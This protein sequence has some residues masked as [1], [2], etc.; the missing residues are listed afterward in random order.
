[1]ALEGNAG[2]SY[3]YDES[4]FDRFPPAWP[5][6]NHVVPQREGP[7]FFPHTPADFPYAMA[8]TMPMPMSSDLAREDELMGSL[9]SDMSYFDFA[10][11]EHLS[12]YNQVP[13]LS[14][15]SPMIPTTGTSF[16]FDGAGM[17]ISGISGLP[18]TMPMSAPAT[19]SLSAVLPDELFDPSTEIPR[20]SSTPHT[21]ANNE[22][23]AQDAH[24]H[25]GSPS[26]DNSE[27]QLATKTESDI[28]DMDDVVVSTAA[29]Q[30]SPS[31]PSASPPDLIH[32]SDSDDAG[33]SEVED[34]DDGDGDFVPN[35]RYKTRGR[36]VTRSSSRRTVATKEAATA[37]PES[38]RSVSSKTHTSGHPRVYKLTAPT[39]VP[40]LTKKSR[41]RRV[42]TSPV[43]VV[44]G[45]VQ[46]NA[47]G[48]TCKV[49]GCG[50]CFA[51]GEHLKRHVRSI[52]TN[53]KRTF[54]L[55]FSLHPLVS[56]SAPS[57]PRVLNFPW[58]PSFYSA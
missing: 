29:S 8:A 17:D 15:N 48:Y 40:N 37:S 35:A 9:S 52:H 13:T 56:L 31:F 22:S 12:S 20:L 25:N 6:G 47:R 54:L 32:E 19:S 38:S 2:D 44:Q 51:R 28:Q 42:P 1:M 36:P 34:G 14:R 58:R 7:T 57:I 43:L 16:Y 10:P 27:T 11:S 50:K 30:S 21:S 49:K 55:L 46:K 5:D 41:G 39:P 23:T 26:Q 18:Y 3:V 4:L 53:E 33:E 24:L 45:G